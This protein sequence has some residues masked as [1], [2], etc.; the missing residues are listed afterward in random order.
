MKIWIIDGD[1][2]LGHALASNFAGANHQVVMHSR[3]LWQQDSQAGVELLESAL[4]VDHFST[5]F[6]QRG[7][8]DC[9]IFNL[10]AKDE[11]ELLRDDGDVEMLIQQLSNDLPNFLR[12]IQT[13]SMLLARAGQGKIWVLVQEDSMG[14][15]VPTP[16]AS[17][18]SRARISAV[19]SLAKEVARLGV[20]INAVSVQAYR[21]QL[22]PAVWRAAREDLKAYALKFKP[23]DA[24]AIAETLCR[25]SESANLPIVGMVLPLAVGAPD[26]NI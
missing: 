20:K 14:Y 22:D 15:Y 11:L 21:E 25:L 5:W 8:P 4:P 6:E 10:K 7:T 16:V 9:V 24:N 3:T 23:I 26:F 13:I 2:A 17:V 18:A 19:K 12:E 1:D